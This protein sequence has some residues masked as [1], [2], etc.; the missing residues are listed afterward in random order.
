MGGGGVNE[1]R[2]VVVFFKRAV[3]HFSTLLLN[4]SHMFDR[5]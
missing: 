5:Q 3:S 2:A 4:H 1:F